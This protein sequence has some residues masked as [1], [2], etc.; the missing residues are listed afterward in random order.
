MNAIVY[1]SETGTTARYAEMFSQATGLPVL[2]IKKARPSVGKGERIIYMGWLMAGQL[3]G[4]REARKLWD[5]A[6]ICAVGMAPPE[7]KTV[8]ELKER[9][10]IEKTPVFVLQGGLYIDKLHGIHKVMMKT[11]AATLGKSIEQKKAPTDT[12]KEMLGFLRQGGDNVR[13]ENLRD[14][15]TWWERQR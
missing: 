14:I 2:D 10:H 4:Y 8:L 7:E 12:E 11:M 5:I 6:A 9:Y 1:T 3:Q 15:I 13:P